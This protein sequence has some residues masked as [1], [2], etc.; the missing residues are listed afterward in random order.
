M[1]SSP[2]F[3]FVPPP[4]APVFK[5]TWE[6]FQDALGYINKIRPIAE[7]SGICKIIPPPDWQPPFAVDVDNFKFTPRIQRLN[8]LEAHTRIKLNFL[9]QIA[10]FW[11]LQGSSLKIP[12]V[13]RKALDLY[14]LHRHVWMEGGNDCVTKERKWNK[15]A[16]RMGFPSNKNLGT[17]LKAHYE[18]ILH[19]FDIFNKGKGIPGTN[20]GVWKKAGSA[21]RIISCRSRNTL[22]SDV[23]GSTRFTSSYFLPS[24]DR[25]EK[26]AKEKIMQKNSQ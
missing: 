19:P 23:G 12:V 15:I 7:Q 14:S 1:S 6:E 20:I 16:T 24:T 18:R 13:E 22:W 5:P 9:D 8:E 25:K 3:Q 21:C 11:E 2:E 17:L 10:K 4:E 26:T